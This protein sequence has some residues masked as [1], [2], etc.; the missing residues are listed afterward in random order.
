MALNF[1]PYPN[2]LW[3]HPY[4]L[5][6]YSLEGTMWWPLVFFGFNLHGLV[7]YIYQNLS[8]TQQLARF[9]LNKKIKDQD[10]SHPFYVND[11]HEIGYM[12][13]WC[14]LYISPSFPPNVSW[15]ARTQPWFCFNMAILVEVFYFAELFASQHLPMLRK[16][17]LRCR[18]WSPANYP[19][20]IVEWRCAKSLLIAQS[21]QRTRGAALW[22]GF[23]G[24]PLC[25]KKWEIFK[26]KDPIHR[27]PFPIGWLIN[28]GVWTNPFNNR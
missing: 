13:W 15:V 7:R 1:D 14:Y 5:K 16:H 4:L 24:P 3:L 8:E 19:P 21:A 26:K 17:R 20:W 23:I 2:H 18:S 25:K 9:L 6:S 11:H 12:N 22:C 27:C 28:R 10:W